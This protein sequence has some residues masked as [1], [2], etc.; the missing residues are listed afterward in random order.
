MKLLLAFVLTFWISLILQADV[1]EVGK[2]NINS[3]LIFSSQKGLNSGIYHFK[4]RGIS[5]EIYHLPIR[6]DF[7]SKSAW[8]YYIKGDLSFSRVSVSQHTLQ[9]YESVIAYGTSIDTYIGGLGGGIRYIFGHGF[10]AS[11]GGEILYS[12]SAVKLGEANVQNTVKNLFGNDFNTNLTYEFEASLNY[13]DVFNEYKIYAD[14]EY[15]LYETKTN[16]SLGEL[17]GFRSESSVMSFSTG[18]ETPSIFDFGTNYLTFEGRVY[19]YFLNG[20]VVNTTGVDRYTTMSGTMYLYVPNQYD[21]IERFFV[22][23]SSAQSESIEGY[24]IGVGFS[25][26]F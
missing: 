18:F 23:V 7:P 15:K 13:M 22:E 14:F 24:N 16:F 10:S 1:Q 12:R 20:T 5:L 9:P 6:Y 21:Y 11:I 2:A 26:K 3:I 8:N 17:D 4:N 25:M 19:E